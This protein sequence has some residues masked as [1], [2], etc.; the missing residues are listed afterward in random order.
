MV[1]ERF[2]THLDFSVVGP[3]IAY[4]KVRAETGRQSHTAQTQA[5]R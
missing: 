2:L 1:I 4:I 3:G 5:K